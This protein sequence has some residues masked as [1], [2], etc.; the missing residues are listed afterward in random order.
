M[1]DTFISNDQLNAF[2]DNQLDSTEKARVLEAIRTDR[3]LADHVQSLQ[4]NKDMLIL[5]YSEY[6][7]EQIKPDSKNN[8]AFA[9]TT[10]AATIML[11]LSGTIGWLSQPYFADSTAPA[12]QNIAKF[13]MASE[14]NERVL[15]HINTMDDERINTILNTAEKILA[16]RNTKN[17]PLKLEIVANASGLGLLREGSKYRNRIKSISNQHMNVSFLACGIAMENARL[18]EGREVKLIPEAT[19]INAA[20]DKILNRIKGGWTYVQG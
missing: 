1:S 16:H 15:L 17:Q 10:V 2:I 7:P 5:T 20:I 4:N 8:W 14:K 19:K 12:M 3:E 11:S 18:K 6:V 9:R 13:D